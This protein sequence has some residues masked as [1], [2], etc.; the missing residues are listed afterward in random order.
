M[1]LCKF[2]QQGTCRNGA[3]CRFEHPGANSANAFGS[4]PN[5][6]AN[7]F[8]S[9]SSNN[10][11]N[12]NNN[13]FGAFGSGAGSNAARPQENPWKI[14]KE[15]IKID[16]ADER[17]T[18]ILSCYGPG[19]DAPEQLFG[20]PDREQSLEE[21]RLFVMGQPDPQAA[22]AK[23]QALYQQAE[24]QM[25]T[26][27]GNLDGAMQ[28]LLA[29]EGKHPNRHDICK[30][31]IGREGGYLANAAAQPEAVPTANPFGQPA[32]AMAT[33]SAFG[34]SAAQP[35]TF[36]GGA[37]TTGTGA[38]GSPAP[39]AQGSAFGQPSAFGVKASPWG[40][41]GAGASTTTATPAFGQ[42][43]FGQ[44]AQPANTGGSAFG[45][46][47]QMGGTSA[48]GQPSALGA[49]SNPFGAGSTTNAFGQPAQP[50]TGAFGQPAQPA[51][52]TS[53]AFGQ[54]AQLAATASAFGQPAQ[55]TTG[56]FGQPAQPAA[57]TSAFGQA[58]A[59]GQ[60]ANPFGAPAASSATSGFGQP[61]A[62]SPFGQAATGNQ[63]MNGVQSAPAAAANPFGQPPGGAFGA[64]ATTGGGAF[65]QKPPGFGSAA[66]PLA[67]NPFGQTQPTAATQQ[68]TQAAPQA[69]VATAGNPYAPTSQKQHPP[70]ESYVTKE[71]NGKMVSF[72]GQPVVYKYKVG[73]KYMDT[74]PEGESM[75][76]NPPTAGIWNQDG[77][78]R[79]ILFPAGAPGYN[80]DTEPDDS[81]KYTPQVKA[82][83]EISAS[84][85]MFEGDMPEVPPMR[86][87]CAWNF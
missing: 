40:S 1:V 13:R 47:S 28:F 80:K 55:P 74:L 3:N 38:F 64:A 12:D 36:G 61:V 7:P 18:W 16:L 31:S 29:G 35:S 39:S 56:A 15:T 52:P 63:G 67:A 11:N 46:P 78:W 72:R 45:Q 8:G 86:E 24:Q 33:A 68:P 32:P 58:S 85:G 22:Y 5:N 81:T 10:S 53:G 73:D 84:R 71:S 19:R 4:R 37:T 41:A 57:T 27:V 21:A 30:L 75:M 6:N 82:A 43:A 60:K 26:A 42:A 70:L 50:T 9:G 34:Q 62:S 2:Y 48:F 49:K 87:D 54:P 77:T 20:G 79:R 66:A 14:T 65:G 69:G 44:P 59:L 51:Q 25:Q 83:Y 23:I 76:Q 17:P